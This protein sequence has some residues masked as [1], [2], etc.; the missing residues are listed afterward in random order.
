[1]C[2]HYRFI[3]FS[4][5]IINQASSTGDMRTMKDQHIQGTRT[6]L[7]EIDILSIGG[8]G[9]HFAWYLMT[10][11]WILPMFY[12][13]TP[14]IES[15]ILQVTFLIGASSLSFV[16]SR[17]N[18]VAI[19]RRIMFT[20]WYVA[21]CVFFACLPALILVIFT[22]SGVSSMPII[23]VAAFLAGGVNSLIFACWEETGGKLEFKNPVFFVAI[24]F[25]FGAS[26]F[27]LFR[28]FFPL[29]GVILNVLLMLG[30]GLLYRFIRDKQGYR[31]SFEDR[32]DI[33]SS[34]THHKERIRVKIS[35][36]FAV[37]GIGFGFAWG[38]LSMRNYLWIVI[39]LAI[40]VLVVVTYLALA[41]KFDN[42]LSV[43]SLQRICSAAVSVFLV[44]V[45][46]T[47]SEFFVSAALCGVFTLWFVFRALNGGLL[48]QYALLNGFSLTH[49]LAAGKVY[50][51]FGVV[52]GW[53]IALTV[54]LA[55]PFYFPADVPAA[56]LTFCILIVS[57]SLLPFE[58]EVFVENK[59]PTEERPK[60][61]KEAPA[62]IAQALFDKCDQTAA[63]YGLSPR[64]RE[65]LEYL[66]RGRNA[67]HI[68]KALFISENT[69]KVHINHIYYKMDVHSQQQLIDF[70]ENVLEY[71]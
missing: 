41:R 5:H 26:L 38:L 42:M 21:V 37:I 65:V 3:S 46:I 66:V 12:P 25:C 31:P 4:E 17:K 29:N 23:G 45:C 67:K 59:K 48:M 54:A 50:T 7:K 30:S 18:T 55:D 36:V 15:M 6:G 60:E 62:E 68:S 24:S 10:I 11:L 2:S 47:D 34:Q 1:M 27:A 40:G 9:F 43:I 22:Y 32:S 16:L 58:R 51:N 14:S 39:A 49:F 53:I 44:I 57:F 28:I 69:A 70:V 52:L 63:I 35:I 20:N 33:E 56:L 19:I 61:T 13:G 64:E 8:F 71:H